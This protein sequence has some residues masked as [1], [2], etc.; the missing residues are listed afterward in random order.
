MIL[1]RFI[2]HRQSEAVL[3]M[4]GEDPEVAYLAA[5]FIRTFT[6]GLWGIVCA[7]YQSGLVLGFIE[8]RHVH[9]AAGQH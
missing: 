3:L 5:E 6:F 2:A 9:C 1:Y 8:I 7:Q 4:T